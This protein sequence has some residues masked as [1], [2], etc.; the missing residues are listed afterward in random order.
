MLRIK[1]HDRGALFKEVSEEGKSKGRPGHGVEVIGTCQE[2]E[3]PDVNTT[4]TTKAA[5]K[6]AVIGHHEKELK[7]EMEGGKEYKKMLTS[8]RRTSKKFRYT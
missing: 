7:K 8:R 2:L 5:V 1:K 4:D 3:I 6:R